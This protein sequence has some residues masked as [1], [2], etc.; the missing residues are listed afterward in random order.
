MMNKTWTRRDFV[1]TVAATAA[2]GALPACSIS[3]SRSASGRRKKVAILTTVMRKHSHGQH[4]VDR[5]LEGYGW[6]GRHHYPNMDLVS[7]YVDQFPDNDLSRDRERRFPLKIYPTLQEAL[8]LGGSKLAVDGVLIIAEHGTYRKDKKGIKKY[9]RHHFFKETVKIFEN[10]ARVVPVFNDKHLST[11]WNECVEMVEDSISLG[12]PFLAGSSLP[13]TWRIPELELPRGIPL[14]ESVCLCYGKVATY[15]FHGYETLQCMS[16]RRHGGEVGVRSMHA[17]RGDGIWKE[18]QGRESTVKLILAALARSHRVNRPDGYTFS[19]INE[20]LVRKSTQDSVA[21]FME[22]YD[23][24]KSSM[25]LF[26]PTTDGLLEGNLVHDFTYA[27]M[28]H[29]GEI[30]SCLMYLPLPHYQA[31][32]ANFF[33]PLVNNIRTR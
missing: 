12:F 8:T 7:L 20:E 16:E 27:G 3:G 2:A 30:Q 15:D 32:L 13:V 29:H 18:L 28:D 33:N 19:V 5:F 22:H 21:F 14:Q 24:Y 25:F 17:I 4:F 10:S 26:G 6:H 9:P 1:K 11:T 31:T 23:G